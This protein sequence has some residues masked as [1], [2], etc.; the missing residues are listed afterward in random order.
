MQEEQQQKS[1]RFGR[2]N[3]HDPEFRAGP[4]EA[5]S[6]PAENTAVAPFPPQSVYLSVLV[7]V[8]GHIQPGAGG[9]KR[10]GQSMKLL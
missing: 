3:Q 1:R 10:R 2:R 8:C 7:R 6:D 4:S 9:V 5:D